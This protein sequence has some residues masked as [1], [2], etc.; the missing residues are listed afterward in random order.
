[1]GKKHKH[2]EHQNMEAWVVSY[3]D[4][5]TLLFALFVVLYAIGETKLRKA[6]II[7]E[8]IPWASDNEKGSGQA[9]TK[10]VHKEANQNQGPIDDARPLIT[11]QSADMQDLMLESLPEQFKTETGQSLEINQTNDTVSFTAPLS[12]FFAPGQVG[13]FKSTKIQDTVRELVRNSQDFTAY[14]RL[15][16]EAPNVVIGRSRRGTLVRSVRL[17]HQ[18]NE[19]LH[20]FLQGIENVDGGQVLTEFRQQG[21]MIYPPNHPVGRNWEDQATLSIAFSNQGDS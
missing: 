18:R 10:G 16:I 3:A 2:E 1:M 20:S 5:L 12:A 7:K 19:F 13:K 21:L 9:P 14:V 8:S 6:K 17:C 4:M 11:S 15:H